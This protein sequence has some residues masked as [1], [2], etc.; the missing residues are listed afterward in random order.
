MFRATPVMFANPGVPQPNLAY[1]SPLGNYTT[2]SSRLLEPCHS[3]SSTH[4]EHMS[5]GGLSWDNHLTAVVL[6]LE[7][8]V[9]QNSLESLLKCRLHCPPPEFL[10]Q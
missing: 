10:I 4:N 1:T 7:H 2:Y 5:P 9:Y 3:L 6:K 8:V